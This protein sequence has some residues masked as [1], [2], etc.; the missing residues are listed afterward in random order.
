MQDVPNVYFIIEV[1]LKC[2][3]PCPSRVT[4]PAVIVNGMA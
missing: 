3:L 2:S 4:S 1:V